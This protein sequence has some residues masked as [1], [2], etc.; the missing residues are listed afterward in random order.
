MT[1][2]VYVPGIVPAVKRPDALI[3]PPPATTDHTGVICVTDPSKS[4]PTARNCW[5]AF[6]MSV[7]FGETVIVDVV[8]ASRGE[9]TS[10]AAVNI[11]AAAI[12]TTSRA[13]GLLVKLVIEFLLT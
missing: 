7:G 10:Q 8:P 2:L 12:A 3:A 5:V 11:P 9:C 1:V 4:L 6:T 13:I